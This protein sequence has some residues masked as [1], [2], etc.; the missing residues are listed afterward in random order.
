MEDLFFGLGKFIEATYDWL[1]VPFGTTRFG[2][3]NVLIMVI[4]VLGFIYWL[5]S[6]SKLSRK[7]IEEE[8]SV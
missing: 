6:Q 3:A 1:L 8:T 4:M 5:T 7:G 2:R